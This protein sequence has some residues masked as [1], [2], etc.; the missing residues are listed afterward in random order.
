MTTELVRTYVYGAVRLA[1]EHNRYLERD[2]RAGSFILVLRK[3]VV[4]A[5]AMRV[6]QFP[7][8]SVA[9]RRAQCDVT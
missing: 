9:Y 7:W 8:D 6:Q 3:H 1:V 4:D 2:F 5:G